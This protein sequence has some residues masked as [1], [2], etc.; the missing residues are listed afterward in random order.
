MTGID[1]ALRVG[2]SGDRSTSRASSGSAAVL[3][4]GALDRSISATICAR[5]ASIVFAVESTHRP[6]AAGSAIG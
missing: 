3:S 6:T 4:P 5:W 1:W 2:S